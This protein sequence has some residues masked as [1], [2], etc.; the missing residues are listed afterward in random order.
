MSDLASLAILLDAPLQAWGVSSRY[1]RRETEAFP[2]KSGLVGLLA[3]ALGVDK[4]AADEPGQIASLA[5]FLVT[6]YRVPKTVRSPVFRLVDFHTV[7]GGYDK[8]AS[9]FEKLSIPRKASGPPFGTVLTRRAYLTDSR[10]AAV[11]TGDA[12]AIRSCREALDDPRWGIWFGRKACLPALPLSPVV[13]DSPEAALATLLARLSLW[14]GG[15]TI[16]A[17][18]LE[19]WEEPEIADRAEGD[20][21]LNDAPVSF[22]ERHFVERA[23]RHRRPVSRSAG[24]IGGSMNVSEAFFEALPDGGEGTID[25]TQDT[26]GEP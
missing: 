3:A 1:Q 12:N 25:E 6:A 26:K 20:F 2:V 24:E 21:F 14:D 7:G 17:E 22:K 18:T 11:F 5:G 16:D 9:T 19:R 15:E 10:F 13:G 8:D 4:N 23:V